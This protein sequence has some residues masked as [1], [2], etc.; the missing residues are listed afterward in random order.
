MFFLFEKKSVII[1]FISFPLRSMRGR[2]LLQFSK[3][4]L[5]S[6][7]ESGILLNKTSSNIEGFHQIGPLGQFGLV[8]VMSV[9]C[10]SFVVPYYA[11]F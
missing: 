2:G 4:V 6:L 10:F 1:K 11:I 8:V 3:A 5:L 7:V 9:C